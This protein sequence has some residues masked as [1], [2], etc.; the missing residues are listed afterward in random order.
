MLSIDSSTRPSAARRAIDAALTADRGRLLGL[1]S[2]WNAQPADA[3]RR[4]AFAEKL[5]AS[6]A[7]RA[8]RAAQLPR[9]E[10]AAEL[11]IAAKV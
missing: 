5:A 4:A 11:P 8:R 7:A 2:K 10:F 9:A 6:L 3:G 1:W